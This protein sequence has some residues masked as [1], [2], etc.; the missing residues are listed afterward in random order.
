MNILFTATA[1][2]MLHITC[3]VTYIPHITLLKYR[4]TK[5]HTL[6]CHPIE[7]GDFILWQTELC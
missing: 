5:G 4:Q 7:K 3:F 1:W 6:I 2:Q